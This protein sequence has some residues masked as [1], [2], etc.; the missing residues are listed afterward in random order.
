MRRNRGV[1][2]E[3][4]KWRRVI[5]V[6]RASIPTE[7]TERALNHTSGSF[8]GVAGVYNLHDYEFERREAMDVWARHVLSLVGS[9]TPANVVPLHSVA[10]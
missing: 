10:P 9:S 5:R 7:V 6:C 4:A 2:I 1:S 8:G 3:F